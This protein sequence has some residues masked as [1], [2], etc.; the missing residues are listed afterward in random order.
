MYHEKDCLLDS[1]GPNGDR[2]SGKLF[3]I[4]ACSALQDYFLIYKMQE[5]E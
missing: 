2:E 1:S 5:L 4:P 3:D